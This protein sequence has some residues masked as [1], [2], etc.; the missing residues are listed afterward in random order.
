M[1]KSSK[2]SPS[3]IDTLCDDAT[4]IIKG[5]PSNQRLQNVFVPLEDRK[6]YS[7]SASSS[8]S[9]LLRYGIGPSLKTFPDDLAPIFPF[10]E[11]VSH[12]YQQKS[13]KWGKWDSFTT[14]DT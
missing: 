1:A 3:V 7:S 14:L 2:K 4:H 9:H 5:L 8:S 10:H 11:K 12:P 13:M 6:A